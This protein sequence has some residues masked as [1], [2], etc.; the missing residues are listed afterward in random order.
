ME[1]RL[2]EFRAARKRAGPAAGPNTSS[3]SAQTSGEKAQ[4]AATPKAAPGWL[5]RFQVWKPRPASTRAQ[6]SLAQ[7]RGRPRPRDLA[8]G[9]LSWPPRKLWPRPRPLPAHRVV[10]YR[11]RPRRGAGPAP[12]SGSHLRWPSWA[13]GAST[14]LRGWAGRPRPL[15]SALIR[16]FDIFFSAR[17]PRSSRL[18]SGSEGLG[19]WKK[20]PLPLS[21]C[22]ALWLRETSPQPLSA[23]TPR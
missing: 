1:Q 21:Y 12:S 11:P 20:A 3:P 9:T 22:D 16:G 15:V 8:S 17:Y 7:V 5:K 23:S 10:A 4:A 14:P 2:A 19:T 13:A 18:Q 6:S